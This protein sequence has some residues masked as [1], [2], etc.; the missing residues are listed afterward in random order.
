MSSS[1]Y[2]NYLF[3]LKASVSRRS[4][5][6]FQVPEHI[7]DDAHV[8]SL[9][10]SPRTLN[11]VRAR[12]FSKSPGLYRGKSP[13]S[14]EVPGQLAKKE[15]SAK[16]TC[17]FSLFLQH[18]YFFKFSPLF[19]TNFLH[20]ILYL[21]HHI[22]QIFLHIFLLFLH[23]FNTFPYNIQGWS[24]SEFFNVPRPMHR[25]WGSGGVLADIQQCPGV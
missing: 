12:N 23:I 10:A 19:Q 9:D 2:K 21:F 7:Y 8:A 13:E 18:K 17:V 15:G 24:S 1:T 6:F 14:V 11:R 5:E 25:E 4:S 16:K 20:N 22:F 3:S